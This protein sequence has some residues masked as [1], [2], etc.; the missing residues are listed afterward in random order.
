MFKVFHKKSSPDKSST[1][2]GNSA[3]L[4]RSSSLRGASNDTSTDPILDAK[5]KIK[6]QS[7]QDVLGTLKKH[8]DIVPLKEYQD[9]YEDIQKSELSDTKKNPLLFKICEDK[10][11]I[12]WQKGEFSTHEKSLKDMFNIAKPSALIALE[13]WNVE[14][15]KNINKNAKNCIKNIETLYKESL[16]KIKEEVNSLLNDKKYDAAVTK[17]DYLTKHSNNFQIFAMHAKIFIK[18][19]D[20]LV[21]NGK[22]SVAK[23]YYKNAY[24]YCKSKLPKDGDVQYYVIHDTFK[25][26]A[27]KFSVV[28]DTKFAAEAATYASKYKPNPVKILIE[29]GDDLADAGNK[30]EAKECYEKAY[31]DCKSKLSKDK[32]VPYDVIHDTFKV[33][34]DK[35]S[36]VGD[37]K[38][39][40]KAA[41]YASKYKPSASAALSVDPVVRQAGKELEKLKDKYE[42][43]SNKYEKALTRAEQQEQIKEIKAKYEAQLKDELE[44]VNTVFNTKLEAL[45]ASYT[46][47]T[48]V[49]VD[50][51]GDFSPTSSL[52][53]PYS[54]VN[55]SSHPYLKLVTPTAPTA[56]TAPVVTPLAEEVK[57]ELTKLADLIPSLE[58]YDSKYDPAKDKAK[59]LLNE[60]VEKNPDVYKEIENPK[61]LVLLAD[62]LL[63]LNKME[64]ARIVCEKALELDPNIWEATNDQIVLL[65]LAGVLLSSNQPKAEQIY[66]KAISIRIYFKDE[67]GNYEM[68]N[69]RTTIVSK[70]VAQNEYSAAERE[71]L[72]KVCLSSNK[73]Y[74]K[75]QAL[76]CYTHTDVNKRQE[77]AEQLKQLAKQMPLTTFPSYQA[78]T[79]YSKAFSVLKDNL[80][81]SQDM[82]KTYEHNCPYVALPKYSSTFYYPPT[83]ESTAYLIGEC[84]NSNY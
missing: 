2:V 84:A 79:L 78:Y 1:S 9:L 71:C 12:A 11:V 23:E 67:R 14:Y 73:I 65:N 19:G 34:E 37:T 76:D 16:I 53:P 46:K 27:D 66:S 25:E 21:A 45:K 83:E 28:G 33:L 15:K 70:T 81:L 58:W 72:V 18:Q 77:I 7:F 8:G 42:E 10:A 40:A 74:Q 41:S 38:L 80:E 48:K 50:E 52:P 17:L 49:E 43:A 47:D 3:T 60:A 36:I 4:G 64:K 69:H 44:K 63:S 82:K 51:A 62:A 54:T 22:T 68:D 24:Q 39:A 29:Q 30:L 31:Q 56:P 5:L 61:I 20:D 32:D 59:K 13:R 55:I 35:L 75:V 6:F 57:N 26:L